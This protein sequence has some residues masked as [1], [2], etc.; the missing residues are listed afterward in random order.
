MRTPLGPIN[1]SG[2]FAMNLFK[3][4]EHKTQQYLRAY[5]HV[6]HT[7]DVSDYHPND[8]ELVRKSQN[9]TPL[10]LRFEPHLESCHWRLNLLQNLRSSLHH[11]EEGLR[12][13][14]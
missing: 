5:A 1:G 6:Y 9:I 2:I 3:G 13:H 7:T 4:Y 8:H 12:S 14:N 11:G 10:L